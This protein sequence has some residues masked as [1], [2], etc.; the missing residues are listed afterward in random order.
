M[1]AINHGL[2]H[3]HRRLGVACAAAGPGQR[4]RAM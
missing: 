3:R 1:V 2:V 4:H